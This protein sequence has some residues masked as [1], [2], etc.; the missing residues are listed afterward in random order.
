MLFRVFSHLATILVLWSQECF[1][2]HWKGSVIIIDLF[3]HVSEVQSTS[4]SYILKRPMLHGK[5]DVLV[6]RGSQ[7]AIY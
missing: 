5:V 7:L 6:I 1:F 2:D 4:I 3:S